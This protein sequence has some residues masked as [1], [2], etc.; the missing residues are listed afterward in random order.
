MLSSPT[1]GRSLCSTAD[2]SIAPMMPNCSRFSGVQSTFAP[3]SSTYVLV[4]RMF[5]STLAI[6]GRSMPASVLS[7]KREIAIR[8]PVLP[9]LT[10]ACASPLFTR[11]TVTRID[12]SFL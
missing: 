4:R 9:A 3:R 1:D 11:L 12:E 6:A 7:T 2:T 10:Q 8:A 5:G